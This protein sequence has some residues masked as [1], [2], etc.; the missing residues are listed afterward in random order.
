MR[1]FATGNLPP[2]LAIDYE[3]P[4]KTMKRG[5]NNSIEIQA[6]IRMGKTEELKTDFKWVFES[7]TA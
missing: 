1:N 2:N 5:L 7:L 6:K 3:I 4:L